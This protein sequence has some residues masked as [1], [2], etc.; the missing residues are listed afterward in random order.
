MNRTILPQPLVASALI[1]LTSVFLVL[2]GAGNLRCNTTTGQPPQTALACQLLVVAP[3]VERDPNAVTI[4]DL[5]HALADLRRCMG[6]PT[7]FVLG[8]T[9]SDGGI[10]TDDPFGI[11]K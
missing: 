8:M 9:L 5:H 1:I 3:I 7:T 6:K 2:L 11:S 10:I 4:D